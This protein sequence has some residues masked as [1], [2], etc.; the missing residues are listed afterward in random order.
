MEGNWAYMVIAALAWNMKA[1]MGALLL[2]GDTR[3]A[4]SSIMRMEFKRF[5]NEF[6][7]IPAQI[8]RTSRRILYRLLSYAQRAPEIFELLWRIRRFDLA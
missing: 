4:G 5:V 1:W 6:I 7:R 2:S 8:V 3:Q